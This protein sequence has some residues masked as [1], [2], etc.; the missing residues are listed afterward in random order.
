MKIIILLLI[1]F[2]LCTAQVNT[3]MTSLRALKKQPLQ[4]Y[5]NDSLQSVAQ[6]NA[7]SIIDYYAQ[8]DDLKTA[9]YS[10]NDS[11]FV[12]VDTFL[13]PDLRTVNNDIS[14]ANGAFFMSANIG[15]VLI[16]VMEDEGFC[17]VTIYSID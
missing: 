7:T 10:L 11:W 8:T 9:V 17:L 14:Q 2:N 12:G 13:G 3:I 1:T 6:A 4:L 15:N 5:K 16:D